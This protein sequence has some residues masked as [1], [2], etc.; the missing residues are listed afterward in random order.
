MFELNDNDYKLLNAFPSPF[1]KVDI[2]NIKFIPQKALEIESEKERVNL[3]MIEVLTNAIMS[4]YN[5]SA[6][7]VYKYWNSFKEEV[8][9][10]VLS[11]V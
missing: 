8:I 7:D 5:C 2:N 10:G 1:E 11:K 3:E 6:D 9:N 4:K